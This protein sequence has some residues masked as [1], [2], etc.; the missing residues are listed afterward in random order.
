MRKVLTIAA[1]AFFGVGALAFT[2]GSA[3]AYIA[4]NDQGDCWHAA[5]RE[6]YA[7]VHVIWHPD[8]WYWQHHW[9]A[10]R[11]HHWHGYH[12]GRGYWRAGVWVSL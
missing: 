8:S 7:G 9:D 2:T 1:A 5:Q 10:D 6:H 12:T 4:C 3:S 11:D